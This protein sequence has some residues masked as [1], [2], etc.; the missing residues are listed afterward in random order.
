MKHTD[1][2]C[3]TCFVSVTLQNG[4]VEV[5]PSNCPNCSS[6]GPFTVS[7]SRVLPSL[8]HTKAAVLHHHQ[9]VALQ[10]AK[11]WHAVCLIAA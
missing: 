10:N 11:F 7:R 6:K 8:Q 5:K 1:K 9:G 3:V 4:D 2:Q